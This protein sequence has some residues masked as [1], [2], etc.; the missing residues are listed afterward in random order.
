MGAIDQQPLLQGI[1]DNLL[2]GETQFH[3]D[4]EAL[5]ADLADKGK[6]LLQI[7]KLGAEVPAHLVDVG[8]KPVEN[9]HE[10]DGDA[11]SQRSA[12]EG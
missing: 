5:A 10:L 3:A 11:A 9:I 6:P 8:Q 1:Q 2:A 7:L 12:A 4:H